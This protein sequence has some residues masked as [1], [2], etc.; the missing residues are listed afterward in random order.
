MRWRA[1]AM[2]AIGRAFKNADK[3]D[4]ELCIAGSGGATQDGRI[5]VSVPHRDGGGRT[6]SRG[7]ASA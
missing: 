5:A 7:G 1:P 3:P 4:A 6:I 2:G